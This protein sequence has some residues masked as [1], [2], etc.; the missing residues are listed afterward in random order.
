MFC[1][2]LLSPACSFDRDGLSMINSGV[3]ILGIVLV[4]Y[5]TGCVTHQ[6]T[7]KE[8]TC[9]LQ[10]ERQ[11]VHC[12]DICQNNCPDCSINATKAAAKSY[13]NY[14]N[15]IC[16]RGGVVTRTLQSYRDPLKCRKP[17]CNCLGDL[18]VC[19]Q[20]CYGEIHKSLTVARACC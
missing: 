2:Y 10:C 7:P 16:V 14:I 5:L 15:E 11:F 12:T 19:M 3:R 9:K 18:E 6:D 17:T 8:K 20:S 13:Q 1:G 4:T